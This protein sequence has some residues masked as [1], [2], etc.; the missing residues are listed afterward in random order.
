MADDLESVTNGQLDVIAVSHRHKDHLSGFGTKARKTQL[1]Q[2]APKLIV[3]S[4]TEDPTAPADFRGGAAW[5]MVHAGSPK[6]SPMA[7]G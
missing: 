5:A 7:Y 1:G 3:R 2:L 4:W 6:R